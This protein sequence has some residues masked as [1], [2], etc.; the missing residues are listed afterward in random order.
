MHGHS[1]DLLSKVFDLENHLSS[2]HPSILRNPAL[3]WKGKV[4]AIP[5]HEW[6]MI[7]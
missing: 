3:L 4:I 7:N 5:D 6:G 2:L 1:F